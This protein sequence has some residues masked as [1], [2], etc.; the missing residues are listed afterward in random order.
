M[1]GDI[2]VHGF[3]GSVCA[4]TQVNVRKIER[5]EKYVERMMAL[6]VTSNIRYRVTVNNGLCR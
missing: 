5:M 2:I 4:A 6:G 1:T 3:K